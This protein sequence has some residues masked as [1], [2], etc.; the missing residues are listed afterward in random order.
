MNLQEVCQHSCHACSFYNHNLYS[1]AA[2]T[3]GVVSILGAKNDRLEWERIFNQTYIQPI[4]EVWPQ[5]GLLIIK[6]DCVD[7]Y[8]IFLRKLMRMSPKRWTALSM[9]IVKVK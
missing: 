3:A 5:N 8:L 1:G 4:L 7:L 6:S 9:M 2:D